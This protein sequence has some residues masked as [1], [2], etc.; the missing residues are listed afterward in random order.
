MGRGYFL[1]DR[2]VVEKAFAISPK[3]GM[4]MM[5]LIKLANY[6]KTVVYH[7]GQPL[8][9]QPGELVSSLRQLSFLSGYSV[10]EVRTI[11]DRQA[12][13]T[14][15]DKRVAHD[16][17]VISI[18]NWNE[19]SRQKN[20][21]TNQR[22]TD[23][24]ANDTTELRTKLINNISMSEK[25]EK[26]TEIH[27]KVIEPKKRKTVKATGAVSGLEAHADLLATVSR[28]LQ[29]GWIKLLGSPARVNE[30]ITK[31]RNWCIAK[32]KT[33]KNWQQRLNNWLNN[34]EPA[35][36]FYE[37]TTKAKLYEEF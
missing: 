22:H 8:E 28:D 36:N 4:L 37:P 34:A 7:N 17:R 29:A 10:R 35:Q 15:I 19:I 32:N 26:E 5:L 6:E 14:L 12:N 16:G 20:E 33:T 13:A 23:R 11:L 1:I 30:E 9:L 24:Q 2:D 27:G 21:A 18:R 3:A 31:C 25:S